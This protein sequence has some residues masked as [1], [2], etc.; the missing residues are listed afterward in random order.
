VLEF[1]V[2]AAAVAIGWA[3]YLNATL[4]QIF[5]VT[6]PT[7]IT[8]PPGD[9]GVVNVFGILL[10]AALVFLLVRGIRITARVNELFVALILAVLLLVVGIGATETSTANWSPFLTFGWEGIVGGAAL[11]FFAFIGFDIV[12]TTAEE[13]R[14]PQRDM[15]LGI[16]GSLAVTTILYV[17]VARS[18][19]GWSPTPH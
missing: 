2:G 17:A 1:T 5:G 9:G 4:E 18:R 10:V 11:V 19:P 15:P 8:G 3:G 13:T 12:A 14:N 16:L 7:A 6:L